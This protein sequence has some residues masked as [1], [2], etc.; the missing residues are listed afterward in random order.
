MAYFQSLDDLA[1]ALRAKLPQQS[2][3]YVVNT[4]LILQTGVNL[5]RIREEQ[6]RDSDVIRT[7]LDALS[8]MGVTLEGGRS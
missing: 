1:A 4:R 7:V 2:N 3:Y 5:R 8:R 6:N